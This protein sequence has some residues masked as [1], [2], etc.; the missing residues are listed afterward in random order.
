MKKAYLVLENGRVFEGLSFGAEANNA[1][2]L[3]FTTGVVGYLET[4]TDPAYFGQIFLQTFPLVGNYGVIEEDVAGKKSYLKGYVV[5]EWCNTP[6][7]F[8]CDYDIDK[9][10]KEQGIPGIYGV[11]TREITKVIREEGVMNAMICSEIPEDM[12]VIKEYKIE[13]GVA[14]TTNDETVVCPADG[15]EKYSVAVLNLGS[16]DAIVKE[17]N[18]KGVKA[19]VVPSS[20]SADDVL[21]MGVDGVVVSDGAGAPRENEAVISEVAKL[22]GKLP[23]LGISLGHQTMA[24]SKGGEIEKLKYGHR[25][26]NQPAKQI[27]GNRSFMTS[28]NHGYV[29]KSATVNGA[30]ESFVNLNDGSCEGLEYPFEKALSVQFIPEK[31]KGPHDTSFI[32]DKFISLMG[33]AK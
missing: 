22:F 29:V 5:R 25:G 32:Y 1:G 6:S 10:L 21:K 23:M 2:E 17:L 8:R 14:N 24:L 18:A 7:N 4:L 27:G 16:Y 28:Q 26:G 11:D 3:V 9:F 15:E 33:G 20:T 12:T 19:T 31:F 30:V 13:G